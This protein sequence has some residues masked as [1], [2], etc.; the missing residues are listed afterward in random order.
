MSP[1]S[2]NR[3]SCD[4]FPSFLCQEHGFQKLDLVD[5]VVLDF[6][7]LNR[8]KAQLPSI[9]RL[10][11]ADDAGIQGLHKWRHVGKELN[12]NVCRLIVNGVTGKVV[13]E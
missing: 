10:E 11:A 13:E 9:D 3:V 12:T 2:C 4:R 8:T 5:I 6:I 7:L 1:T